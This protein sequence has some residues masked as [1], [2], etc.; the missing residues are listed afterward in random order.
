MGTDHKPLLALI[1]EHCSV[2]A[3]ASAR[4]QCGPC[5]MEQ[6][7]ESPVSAEQ[8]KTWTSRDVI[9]SQ[10]LGYVLSG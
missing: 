2:P 5:R 7:Q 4:T 9:P 8:I 10:V 1:G 3:Q 6:L